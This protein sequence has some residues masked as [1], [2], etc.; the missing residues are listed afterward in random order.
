MRI[1][2]DDKDGDGVVINVI[3]DPAMCIDAA[4]I[5]YVIA[6]YKRFGMTYA[7]TRC[8]DYAVQDLLEFLI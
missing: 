1:D 6:A 3:D 5:G 4:R 8:Q 2:I 7:S